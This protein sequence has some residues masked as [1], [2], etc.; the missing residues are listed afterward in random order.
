MIRRNTRKWTT[1][2]FHPADGADWT[3]EPIPLWLARST[4]RRPSFWGFWKT[5]LLRGVA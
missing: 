4:K 3:L 1:V 2:P 5:I